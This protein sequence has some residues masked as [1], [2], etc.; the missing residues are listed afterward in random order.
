M[1]YGKYLGDEKGW[2]LPLVLLVMAVL[3]IL[4]TTLWLI[5]MT[6]LQHVSLEEKKMQAH[7]Y[8]RSGAELVYAGIES[9]EYPIGNIPAPDDALISES[10]EFIF[11]DE[12]DLEIN[13]LSN[14]IEIKVYRGIVYKYDAD[15]IVIISTGRVAEVSQTLELYLTI[16]ADEI[17]DE[18]WVRK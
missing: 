16:D 4:G 8:A 17:V 12:D 3:T 5:S 10:I 15:M 7:Y 18:Y 2:A 11:G 14:N 13:D 6:D 9:G 1:K